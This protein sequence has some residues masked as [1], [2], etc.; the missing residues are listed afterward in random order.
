MTLCKLSPDEQ[1]ARVDEYVELIRD[2]SRE[3]LN[4]ADQIAGELGNERLRPYRDAPMLADAEARCD[5]FLDTKPTEK[6]TAERDDAQQE[7][8][9]VREQIASLRDREAALVGTINEKQRQIDEPRHQV[10]PLATYIA[11]HP[12]I[13]YALADKLGRVESAGHRIACAYGGMP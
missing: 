7:L 10:E 11:Q 6:L 2:G 5:R 4:R 3:A 12:I 1:K 13:G 8:E 9:Q